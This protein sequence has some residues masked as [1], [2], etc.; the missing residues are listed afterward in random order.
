[1]IRYLPLDT[2]KFKY[3]DK[4]LN[5]FDGPIDFAWWAEE[6]LT[7][8]IRGDEFESEKGWTESALEKYPELIEYI[9]KEFPFKYLVYVKLLRANVDVGPHEDGNYI[10]FKGSNKNYNTI[11]KSYL[12]HQLDTEPCGYRMIIKGNRKNLYMCDY[13]EYTDEPFVLQKGKLIGKRYCTLPETTDCFVLQ[14]NNSPHGVDK[15]A[16][17]DNRL[18]LFVIGKLDN[19]KHDA[20]INRSEEIYSEYVVR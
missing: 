17:D 9:T 6:E 15:I 10:E 20:L 1:M 7:E 14:T 13:D 4:V 3:K 5:A 12:Q 19:E 18:L 2:P 11:S 16:N 8:R